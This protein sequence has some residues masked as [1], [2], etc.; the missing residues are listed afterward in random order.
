MTALRLLSRPGCHLCDEA[1]SIL[2]RMDISFA[3]INVEADVE[4]ERRYGKLIPVLLHD[5]QE[6]AHAPLDERTL[7]RALAKVTNGH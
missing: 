6:I 3:T 7:R 4:L 1:A 2:T 5:G